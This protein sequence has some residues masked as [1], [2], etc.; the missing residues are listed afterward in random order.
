M[1]CDHIEKYEIRDKLIKIYIK[2]LFYITLKLARETPF[3]LDCYFF[4]QLSDQ[5]NQISTLIK[6]K[7]EETF[8]VNVKPY[9]LE[10]YLGS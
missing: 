7:K 8:L 9:S 2:K 10:Y 3:H 1:T 6:F 4:N 5:I